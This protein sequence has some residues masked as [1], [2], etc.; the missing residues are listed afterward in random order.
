[1]AKL[2]R[3]ATKEDN[4]VLVSSPVLMEEI[5]ERTNDYHLLTPKQF[6]TKYK[7]LLFKPVD[8]SWN[9]ITHQI[10]YNYCANPFCKWHGLPQE[11]FDSKGKPSR[12]RLS[13]TGNDKKLRCN[14][15]PIHLTTGV[16]LDCH[17]TTLS[18]WSIAQEI[19]RLI[20]VNGVQDKVPEYKFHK[21]G[22]AAYDCTPFEEPSAFYKQGKSSTGTQRWQCKT[23]KKKTTLTP[24]RKQSITYNQ[25]R[26]DVLH[27]F[28]K[29]LL[30]RTPITRTCE[31]LEIGRGTYYDKLEF[32]YRRCLEF[33]ERHETKPLQNKQ[34]KEMW[35]NTDKM[36][37]FLNNVRKKGMGGS[38]YDDLEESNFPTNVVVSADVFS[39][40]VFRSDV[41]YD[42]D[43]NLGDIALDTIL[44]K[45]DHLNEFAK[46]YARFPKYSHYPMPPSRNDTQTEAE[47][48][49][50]LELIERREKYIDGLHINSTYTTIAHFWLIK[51]IVQASEWRFITD[52]DNS[53]MTSLHRV[54]AKE[55]RLSDAYHFLCQTDKT[56]TRKQARNEFIQAR[57]DLI[58]WGINSGYDTR[59]LRKL[60]FLKLEELFHHHQFHKVVRLGSDN[61]YEYADNPIEHPLATIDRGFRWV[62]CTSDLSSLEPN[63]I[64]NLILNVNDNATNTFIQHIRRKLSIL[65]RPLT[66]ARGEGK[67]YIYSNFNPK[68]AQMALTIL[69]TYYNFCLPFKTKDEVGTPAQRLGIA[70]KVFDLRD[71]IY[72]R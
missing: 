27:L 54:F 14:P 51:Q 68:Y 65:E 34:F 5:S 70:N 45:E 47:Y 43:I 39:R 11:K 37:Y 42:W 17:N 58:N 23:C 49:N 25:K 62:D 26:S 50:E 40:Y 57:T 60:A 61:H 59:S 72:L 31:I 22:C 12:Y 10:Q 46:K 53:L 18:N 64:A 52:E 56:K 13:G 7:D 55:F 1:M 69:R 9:G 71:I 4:L 30:S 67:S 15:D 44:L 6:G 38:D 29:L 19:E 28:T 32:I 63:D 24:N 16:A 35:I 33:L 21:D 20:R 66:T 36:T 41:A 8:F 3:L 2:K 48:R